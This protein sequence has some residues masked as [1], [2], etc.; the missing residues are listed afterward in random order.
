MSSTKLESKGDATKLH[1]LEVGAELIHQQG[2]NNTGIA[3]ILK[4]A[5]VAKGSFYFHFADKEAFGIA[6]IDYYINRFSTLLEPI[7]KDQTLSPYNKISVFNQTFSELFTKN[8][9]CSGCPIGNLCQEMSGISPTFAAKLNVALAR[10][11]SAFEQVIAHGIHVK[12]FKAELNPST[13]AAFLVDSWEGAVLR[14][15]LEKS[16]KP[17]ENWF[18]FMKEMLLVV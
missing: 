4:S 3:Q 7:F 18:A 2:F 16:V 8:G 15:K 10:M 11:T 5:G 12:E 9:F 14:M 6:V 13:C 17:L 1:L